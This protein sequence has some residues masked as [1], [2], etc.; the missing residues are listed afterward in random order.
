MSWHQACQAD[1]VKG[2]GDANSLAWPG[3]SVGVRRFEMD[4]RSRGL[5]GLVQTSGS[6]P[7]QLG[8]RADQASK[9]GR[10][11]EVTMS[12][13]RMGPLAVA[14]TVLLAGLASVLDLSAQTAPPPTIVPPVTPR[15]ND[16]GPQ[17]TIPQPG[18]PV[19]QPSARGT[20]SKIAPERS[21][22]SHHRPSRHYV[23][24]HRHVSGT[25]V[26]RKRHTSSV[27][28]I[29]SSSASIVVCKL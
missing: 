4:R 18:N 20:E 23:A 9:G 5:N 6:R 15:L 19:Q 12:I 16:P 10:M 24:K 7:L 1:R 17:L 3:T 26:S 13:C 11:K 14:A 8:G 22:N 28:G 2:S 29:A 21:A 27:K 25:H